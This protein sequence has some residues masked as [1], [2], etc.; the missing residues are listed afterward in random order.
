M[1]LLTTTLLACC[2]FAQDVRQN[3]QSSSQ[4][5][6]SKLQKTKESATNE[7][8]GSFDDLALKVER[9]AQPLMEIIEGT[10]DPWPST[11]EDIAKLCESVSF[12]SPPSRVMTPTHDSDNR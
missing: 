4:Q 6:N 3:G 7:T 9:C 10:I 2:C 11:E 12:H 8:C 1:L 5:T